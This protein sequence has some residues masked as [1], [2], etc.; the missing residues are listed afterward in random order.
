LEIA[1]VVNKG[2]D[3]T[4]QRNNKCQFRMQFRAAVA[5]IVRNLR[6]EVDDEAGELLDLL[7][8]A[9]ALE[10]WERSQAILRT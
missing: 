1:S 7:P 4:S 9:V 10:K 3:E 6:T 5:T 8:E 2:C